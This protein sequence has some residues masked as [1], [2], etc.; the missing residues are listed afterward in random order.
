M[1]GM[2]DEQL[3]VHLAARLVDSL[4]AYLVPLKVV[5]TAASKD[6][7]LVVELDESSAAPTAV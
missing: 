2:K 1:V 7:L 3:V 4:A 6:P 5:R